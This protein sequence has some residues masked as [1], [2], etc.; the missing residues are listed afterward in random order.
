MTHPHPLA[1][2]CSAMAKSSQQ[3]CR[4]R[5]VLGATVCVVHGGRAPQVRQKA[6]ERVALH[7]ALK[8]TPSRHPGMVLLDSVHALDV[9]QQHVREDLDGTD[10]RAVERWVTSVLN[11]A[12]LAR[13]ALSAESEDRWVRAQ[14]R[15]AEAHGAEVAWAFNRVF[16]LLELDD[17]QRRLVP[18]AVPQALRELASMDLDR[19]AP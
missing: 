10:P 2:Q 7:E 4:Q 18:R 19:F 6:R 12:A 8:L 9:L 14:E 16:E 1:M 15:V 17:R 11:A 3:R 13:T 5:A